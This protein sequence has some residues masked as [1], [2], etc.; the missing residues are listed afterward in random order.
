[1]GVPGALVTFAVQAGGGT[2]LRD[3]ARTGADGVAMPGEWILGPLPGENRV[4]ATLGTL[5]VTF[6]ATARLAVATVP[7]SG[8]VALPGGSTIPLATLRVVSGVSNVPVSPTGGYTSVVEPG[9]AQL[10]AVQ[11]PAGEPLMFGWLEANPRML[12]ARSTAEVLAYFD[13][14]AALLPDSSHRRLV[15]QALAAD[16]ALAVLEAAVAQALQ[17]PPSVAT[18]ATPGVEQARRAVQTALAGAAGSVR[19]ILINPPTEKSGVTVDQTG[20]RNL[21]IAN[22]WRR[23]LYGFVDRVSYV[24]K[25]ST[26]PLQAALAGPPIPIPAVTGITGVISTIIDLLSR[27][28]AWTPVAAAPQSVPLFPPD[29]LSTRYRVTVVGAGLRVPGSS[30]SAVQA[31]WAEQAAVETVLLDF[32]LPLFDQ[33]LNADNL[34]RYLGN[35]PEIDSIVHRFLDLNPQNL[36]QALG[37]GDWKAIWTELSKLLFDTSAGQS[38]FY[39]VI[40]VPH[41]ASKGL[42]QIQAA[43]AVAKRWSRLLTAIE[44][45][46]TSVDIGFVLA[47]ASQAHEVEQWDVTVGG[48]VVTLSPPAPII[49]THESPNIQAYVQEATGGTGPPFVYRWSTTGSVGKLCGQQTSQGASYCG[50][51]F[52]TP[53]DIVAYAP[54]GLLEGTDQIKVEVLLPENGILHAVGEATI[55]IKVNAPKVYLSPLHQ[56]VLPGQTV[57]FTGSVDAQLLDGGTVTYRWRTPGAFGNF[58]TGIL[59]LES[60]Q[61]SVGYV[62][63]PTNL[64]TDAITLEVYSTLGGVRRL[65][66]A[67]SGSVEVSRQPTIVQGGWLIAPPVPLDAGRQCLMAYLT[68][69][70]VQGAQSYEVHAYGF[71]DTATGRTEIRETLIPPFIPWSGCSVAGWG[72]SGANGNE[73][74]M[75]LTGT[76]GPVS[77]AAGVIAG[78]QNRFAGMTVEVTVRY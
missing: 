6:T 21:T 42:A 3:T 43:D 44:V 15:R 78:F 24:P 30:V 61:A 19:S 1:M 71:N 55:T 35:Q 77:G 56:S 47:H 53:R 39:E 9:M 59:D 51:A 4:T 50:T 20:Y 40:I 72:G 13:A 33:M 67:V 31:Q 28:F 34:R 17:V 65:L 41:A 52:D 75:L 11:T 57:T 73:Y 2:L 23:R 68:F 66:G 37:T 76:A 58:G 45:V 25:G 36:F 74:W 8:T 38:F 26:Q 60:T 14:G 16:Q 10:A 7:V 49:F 29:A 5:V 12:N 48:A 22:R 63:N 18:L 62:A 69:P 64:G 46:A 32:L 70:M 27:N 54:H